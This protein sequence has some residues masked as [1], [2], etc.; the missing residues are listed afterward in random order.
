MPLWRAGGRSLG[1]PAEAQNRTYFISKPTH[2]LAHSRT[3]LLIRAALLWIDI[4]KLPIRILYNITLHSQPIVAQNNYYSTRTTKSPTTPIGHRV[5]CPARWRRHHER[6]NLSFIALHSAYSHRVSNYYRVCSAGRVSSPPTIIGIWLRQNTHTL[7]SVYCQAVRD[8]QQQ[9]LLVPT[10]TTSR[11]SNTSVCKTLQCWIYRLTDWLTGH[12]TRRHVDRLWLAGLLALCVVDRVSQPMS[13][14]TTPT[15]TGW[16][17]AVP[18][19]ST[20]R[21]RHFRALRHSFCWWYSITL[22][23][24]TTSS[25]RAFSPG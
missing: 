11:L 7:F 18:L 15:T 5:C 25:N 3:H 9:L 23:R 8:S 4:T 20:S 19:C 22:L 14:S 12:H 24:E 6:Q 1:Q 16:C 2:P 13:G 21:A 17:C 10:S